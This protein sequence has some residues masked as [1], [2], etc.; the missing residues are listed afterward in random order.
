MPYDEDDY[1]PEQEKEGYD[2]DFEIRGLSPIWTRPASEAAIVDFSVLSR[3]LDDFISYQDQNRANL[4]QFGYPATPFP[5]SVRLQTH[6]GKLYPVKFAA[7]MPWTMGFPGQKELLGYYLPFGLS[8][9]LGHLCVF[10]VPMKH[11]GHFDDEDSERFGSL[12]DMKDFYEDWAELLPGLSA[13]DAT[14]LV[15]ERPKI[16]DLKVSILREIS[17]SLRRD[18]VDQLWENCLPVLTDFLPGDEAA[19]LIN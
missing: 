14:R 1:Y 10:S 17:D 6:L 8:E 5:G 18:R 12:E 9:R 7:L 13:E 3:L 2:A 16:L 15:T 11:N 4:H 19:F